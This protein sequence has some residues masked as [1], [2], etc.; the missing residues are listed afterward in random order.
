METILALQ[1]AMKRTQTLN[2]DIIR[3]RNMISLNIKVVIDLLEQY[4]K[5]SNQLGA[6]SADV[7]DAAQSIIREHEYLLNN[8]SCLMDRTSIL[9]D[10]VCL[11]C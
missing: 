4:R 9:S 2:E 10:N 6:V 1:Q 7:D 5:Y 11:F 3:A 8:V